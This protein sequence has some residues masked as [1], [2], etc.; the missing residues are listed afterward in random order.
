M[1]EVCLGVDLAFVTCVGQLW[2][3]DTLSY[4]FVCTN[5]W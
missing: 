2:I 3:D 1:S 5:M 4:A